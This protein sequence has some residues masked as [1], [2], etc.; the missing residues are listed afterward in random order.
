[1]PEL[2]A[3][4]GVTLT[5]DGS[6]LTAAQD[7]DIVQVAVAAGR[8]LANSDNGKV[9][10]CNGTF[11]ITI[12][13]GLDADFQCVVL[14][15]GTGVISFAASGSTVIP[16]ATTVQL[17][18]LSGS[19]A[20][21]ASIIHLGSDKFYLLA[22]NQERAVIMV[23]LSDEVSD[24]AVATPAT[25][26]RMPFSMIVTDVRASV[27]TAPTG[28]TVVVD[29]NEGGTTILSTKL[30]IDASEKTSTTAATPPVI[31][32]SALADDAEVTFDI[33]QV[34]SSVKGAGLKVSLIGY[35]VS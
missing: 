2:A 24:L 15:D 7:P 22:G 1:M 31:S 23:P 29:I 19:D 5:L 18:S 27:N 10:V 34:G 12:P 13:S 17:D 11:T 4:T 9:L 14:N 3:G 16:T 28:A 30:S 35:R 6:T 25:T 33:D 8:S 26:I 20:A 21:M 32:D